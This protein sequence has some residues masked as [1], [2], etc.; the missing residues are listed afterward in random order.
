[1]PEEKDKNRKDVPAPFKFFLAHSVWLFI[2]GIILAVAA[3]Y[4]FFKS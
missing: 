4:S 2:I 3:Y 1:M